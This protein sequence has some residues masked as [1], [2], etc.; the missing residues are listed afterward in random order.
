MPAMW[1]RYAPSVIR[2][3]ELMATELGPIRNISIEIPLKESRSPGELSESLVG[4]LDLCRSLFR[5]F[6]VDMRMESNADDLARRVLDLRVSYEKKSTATSE[7]TE[8]PV[9]E[10]G[11]AVLRLVP[12]SPGVDPLTELRSELAD[13]ENARS[14][15][16]RPR[17]LQ[18]PNVQLLCDRGTA[19]LRSRTEI[20]WQSTGAEPVSE[21]LNSDRSENEILLDVF[22]RRVVGG[23]IPVPDYN[24]V[25]RALS[26][27]HATME[28]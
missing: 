14:I 12:D 11:C 17:N 5:V 20:E 25:C 18:L 10:S 9:D 23:L 3:Q 24:D 16:S 13:F 15:K 26:L 19:Q 2:L 8:Q 28:S 7:S 4:W 22:C 27:L 21:K 1:R 6:P